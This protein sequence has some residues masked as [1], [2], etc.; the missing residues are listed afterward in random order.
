MRARLGALAALLAL[1]ACGSSNS[2]PGVVSADTYMQSVCSALGPWE[3]D[4]R[5]RSAALQ[6]APSATAP[7]RKHAVQ[8]F[9]SAVIGDTGA[10]LTRL[11]QART[12]NIP[13]GRNVAGGLVTA[14][15]QLQ[16]T[17][18]RAARQSRTLPTRSVSQLQAAILGIA[19]TVDSSLSTIGTRLQAL[20]TPALKQ[21]AA[22]AP[23]CRKISG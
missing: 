9:L 1:A 7:E 4:L 13:G 19:T 10:A 21:A 12:P 15:T 5:A 17:Y 11:R 2:H 16:A 3:I 8:V 22:K 20:Q 18:Q 14:F 6:P 23:A